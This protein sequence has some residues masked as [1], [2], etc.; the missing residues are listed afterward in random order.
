MVEIRRD[1]LE[2]PEILK[3]LADHMAF[4]VATTPV[5]ARHAL[6]VEK[7]RDPSITF[8]SMWEGDDLLGCGALRELDAEHGEVKSMHTVKRHRGRGLAKKMLGHIIAEAR[9]RG[10]RHLSLETGSFE[11]FA[12]AVALYRSAGFTDRDAFGD[13]KAGPLTVFL[14]LEL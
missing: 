14:T 3:L 1:P 5:E 13:Y 12:P 6:D 2:G 4:A 8:W 9:T 11:A 7:L 10:Y